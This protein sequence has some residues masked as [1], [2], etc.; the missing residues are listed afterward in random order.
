MKKIKRIDTKG[1]IFIETII[2]AVFVIGI[3]TFLFAN[4][5]PLFAEYEKANNYDTVGAKYK[6]NEIRK[7]VLKE[8]NEDASRRSV[9]STGSDYIIYN[10]YEVTTDNGVEL[11]NELC[12]NLKAVNYCNTLL[13]YDYLNVKEII[14]APFKLGSLK[15]NIK[16]DN[17]VSRAL[18]EYIDYLPKYDNYSVRYNNYNRLIVAFRNGEFANIEVRYEV[19]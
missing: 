10:S 4:F 3:C 15:R 11:H 19:G 2:V 8:I 16:T 18:K 6:V 1:F 5:L 14:I 17:N 12:D 13:G 7:Y 9:L